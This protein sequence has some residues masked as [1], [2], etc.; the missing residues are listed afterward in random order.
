MRSAFD[1]REPH[2]YVC[3]SAARYCASAGRP[4]ERS[5]GVGAAATRAR[6][7][8]DSNGFPAS[9]SRARELACR[10]LL[11]RPCAGGHPAFQ[12][13][14]ERTLSLGRTEIAEWALT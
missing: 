12:S 6:A 13:G 8:A 5:P 2:L 11:R 10:S 3:L 4:G 9:I 7:R 14:H 1:T